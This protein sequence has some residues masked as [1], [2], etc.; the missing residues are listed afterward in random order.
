MAI[1]TGD[2]LPEGQLLKLGENGPETVTS[3]EIGKGRAIVFAVPGA[4]TPV[5]TN[6]HMPGII[7]NAEKLREKGVE[8]I[9]CITVNDPFVTKAW[10]QETG[11]EAAGIEVLADADGSFTRALDLA[12]DAPQ[13]GFLGRSKR[14]AM[15]LRDGVIEHLQVED[16]PGVCAVTSGDSLLDLV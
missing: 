12:F 8:R 2:R 1:S 6:A 9:T 7:D 10:A 14:Y 15:I 3:A 5:C 16:S 11:A 13:N 4:Y